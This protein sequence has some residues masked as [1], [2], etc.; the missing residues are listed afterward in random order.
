MDLPTFE[1]LMLP[2]LKL[3]VEG[4]KVRDSVDRLTKLLNLSDEQIQLKTPKNQTSV[5]YGRV[6]W[7]ITYLRMAGLV[8]KPSRGYYVISD[9][10][11]TILEKSEERIDVKYLEKH[12]SFE[13]YK[14]KKKDNKPAKIESVESLT[15]LEQIEEA[16]ESIN[17]TVKIELLEKIL[18]NSP[19]FFENLV[20]ELLKT[21][22]YGQ[23]GEIAEAIGKTND[24]GIDGV[25]YEDKLGL[26]IVYIQAK[27]Y[28][29]KNVIGRPA[30]QSFIGSLSGFSASKGVFITTSSFSSNVEEYLKS[31]QQRVITIDG[32]RLVELMLK[33]GVGVRREAY[34][35]IFKID[36]DYFND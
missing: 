9:L 24:G 26:D 8:D 15:P 16:Y 23:A 18:S 20:V 4:I 19:A 33:Y 12:T 28:E 10:G 2:C 31:V 3:G 21:M 34:Y 36:E 35:E 1:D 22:G 5:F 7:A 11:R 25:I 30:L 6:N 29:P 13:R 32:N 17:N 27:R 14:A